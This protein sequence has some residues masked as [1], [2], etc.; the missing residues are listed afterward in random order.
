M[1][2]FRKEGDETDPILSKRNPGYRHI[3]S[4]RIKKKT[5]FSASKIQFKFS[6]NGR[7]ATIGILFS[8]KPKRL[9]KNYFKMHLLFIVCVCSFKQMVYV[10]NNQIIKLFSLAL[11]NYSLKKEEV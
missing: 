2:T 8:Q 9:F 5:S 6:I 4:I 1:T 11:S 7:H 10:D 3:Q